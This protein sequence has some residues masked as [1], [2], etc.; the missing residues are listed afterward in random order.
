MDLAF[1]VDGS[2]SICDADPNFNYAVDTTCDNWSFIV[3]FIHRIV[4]ELT[5][6]PMDTRVALVTFSSRAALQWN[7]TRWVTYCVTEC[8]LFE[9]VLW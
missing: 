8:P 5:I 3:Q 1:V 9:W 4:S 2:G 6:G 7:L